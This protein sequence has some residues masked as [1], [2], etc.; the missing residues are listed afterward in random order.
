[1]HII[2]KVLLLKEQTP[3]NDERGQRYAIAEP[4]LDGA[5][6]Q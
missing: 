2:E 1:V 6:E 4:L 5:Q 3:D